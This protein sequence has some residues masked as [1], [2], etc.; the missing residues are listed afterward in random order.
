[1]GYGYSMGEGEQQI[2]EVTWQA[3]KQKFPRANH[4]TCEEYAG[5]V[6]SHLKEAR[7]L[8]DMLFALDRVAR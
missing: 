2:F 8:A 1:M 5:V 7:A 4:Y 3:L 6:E